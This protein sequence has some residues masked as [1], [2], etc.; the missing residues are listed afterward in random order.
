MTAR[1]LPL[2][3]RLVPRPEPPLERLYDPLL[4]DLVRRGP[5]A[6]ERFATPWGD[7]AALKALAEAKRA[8]L[9]RALAEALEADHRRLGASPRSLEHLGMLSRGAAVCAVAGQQPAPLGGPLYSAHKIAAAVGL[10]AAFTARTGMAC[11][12]VY[13]MHGEDSDFA[14]IRTATLADPQLQLHDLALPEPAH[15]EGGLVGAIP[16]ASLAALER[17]ALERWE[18]LPAKEEVGALLAR[19]RERARDLGDAMTALALELFGE[20]GLVV[21]DPRRPAFREAAR[22]VIDR[23]LERPEAMADLARRAGEALEASLGRRPLADASL[24]SFV[25]EIEDGVRR[26]IT[27]AEARR[28]SRPLSPSVALRPVVQDAVLPTVAMACGPGEAAYLAQ[29]R[30]VFEALGVRA[31]SAVP[32]LSATWLPPAAV[33]L[34]EASGA[35]PAELVT[36][37]DQVL[38]HFAEREVPA[39][40]REA[41]ERARAEA[42][43]GLERVSDQAQRVDPSLTQM[44]ESARAKVDFQYARLT[45]GL[46]GKVRHRLERQHPTWPRLRYYLFP[47]ER[48]QERRLASLEPAAYRGA[49][50]MGELCERAAEHAERLAHGVLEHLVIEL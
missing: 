12:P 7:T 28:S 33:E 42:M 23:Y 29:L 13:W 25:F 45:E 36:A 32:R 17:E 35:E 18:G 24:D 9:P 38:K 2:R 11:V 34:L 48:P 40:A 4:D 46:M 1:S 10:A 31:A 30:E 8:P 5:L 16:S 50:V 26:K 19:A 41:L 3:A 44:V 21:V 6:R 27:P 47:G 20:Q 14:E 37:T 43:A 49:V 39:E 22:P 15:P